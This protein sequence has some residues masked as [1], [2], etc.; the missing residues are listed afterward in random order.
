MLPPQSG[1][2]GSAGSVRKEGASSAPAPPELALLSRSSWDSLRLARTRSKPHAGSS[3]KTSQG[4]CS[5]RR[6]SVA[7][8]E[9]VRGPPA[10]L[11]RCRHVVELSATSWLNMGCTSSSMAGGRSHMLTVRHCWMTFFTS[12]LMPSHLMS[13]NFPDSSSFAVPEPSQQK[14]RQARS[15]KKS[16]RPM[17]QMSTRSFQSRPKRSSGA[18][19][20]CV[21]RSV[22]MMLLPLLAPILLA[23][24][25]SAM[26][27]REAESRRRTFAGFRSRCTTRFR[28]RKC[29]PS[30]S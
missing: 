24:L 7:P 21:P 17:A 22:S 6:P 23:L 9:G 13:G 1:V 10:R 12:L 11:L 25:K 30:R 4:S 16:V 29:T 8:L 28:C 14:G 26:R 5:A 2:E 20:R 19:K 18:L 27:S 15:M 3:A